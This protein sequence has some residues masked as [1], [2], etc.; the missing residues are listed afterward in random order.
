MVFKRKV[1]LLG[2]GYLGQ[3]LAGKILEE[4][5]LELVCVWDRDSERRAELLKKYP[6]AIF[7]LIMEE[8]IS[9]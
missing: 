3:F 6:E 2:C 8:V 5:S 7:T 1:A 4:P 9:L